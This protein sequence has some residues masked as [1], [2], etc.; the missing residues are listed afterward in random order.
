MRE[1]VSDMLCEN[2]GKEAKQGDVFCRG[3]GARL[4]A[5]MEPAPPA[6]E[7]ETAAAEAGIPP[8]PYPPPPA[9]PRRAAGTNP[10]AVASLVLGILSFMCLPFIAAI[11]AIVFGA[12]ARGGIKRSGG[13]A[14]G[15]GMATAGIVLGIVN[16]AILILFAAFMVPWTIVNIGRTE[17]VTRTVAAQGAESVNATLE[18]DSGSLRVGGG[19]ADM[20]RG[21]FTYNVKRWEPEISY[22]VRQGVG[23]LSV[24]QGGDWWF[25]AFWFIRNEWDVSFSGSVPLDLSAR[26]SSGEGDFDLGDLALLTFSVEASSGG[27]RADLSGDLPDLRLIGIDTSSGDIDLDLTGRYQTYIQMDIDNSS[28]D[29]DVDLRGDWEGTLDA[30]IKSSSGDLT[31]NVPRDVG[32]RVRARTRSGEVNAPGMKVD[33]EGGEGTVYVNGAFRR[34]VITLQIDVD[35]SSGDITLLLE[36]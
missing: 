25:P 3:C 28:G 13:E 32:V 26:L 34:A 18:I 21:T 15:S 7:E 14:G 19:A 2:C 11:A 30:D 24:R 5:E 12:V 31:I 20:F 4:G 17:T 16:L 35:T 29:I 1:G 10:W 33:S 22:G 8:L 6:G 23:E 9:P 27:V 36:D